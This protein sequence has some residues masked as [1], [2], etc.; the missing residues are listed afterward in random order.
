MS[1]RVGKAQR[2]AARARA[3]AEAQQAEATQAAQL[4]MQA[5]EAHAQAEAQAQADAAAR[6]AATAADRAAQE[7]ATA[8]DTAAKV[9]LHHGTMCMCTCHVCKV[10]S[11]CFRSLYILLTCSW[12]PLRLAFF[13]VFAHT[14]CD[15][16]RT[17]LNMLYV[18]SLWLQHG[19][20][21]TI[22]AA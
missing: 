17:E 9:Q 15:S 20:Y 21:G 6:T 5:A 1:T 18:G 2:A 3:E 16:R 13:Q 8:A 11:I 4:A 7:A 22:T 10:P 12:L 14:V 19:G